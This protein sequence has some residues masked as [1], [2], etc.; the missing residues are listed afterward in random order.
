MSSKHSEVEKSSTLKYFNNI[1]QLVLMFLSVAGMNV[2][3]N[4]A[5]F[6]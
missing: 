1:I 5:D 3:D 6:E 4:N 2:I